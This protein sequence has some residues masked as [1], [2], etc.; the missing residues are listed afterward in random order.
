MSTPPFVALPASV[1]RARWGVRGTE[2]AVLHAG[3][4]D[5]TAWVVM[6]PGFTGSKEDF[7]AVLPLLADAG[8]GVVTFDQIGQ[9]ESDGSDRA[10]DY[11]MDRLAADVGEIVA[12]AAAQFGRIDPPHLLGHSFGGLVAS[13]AVANGSVRPASFVAFC[14]GPGALPP[15]RW[16]TLPDLVAALE[17]SQLADIWRIMREMEVAEDVVPPPPDVAAF[18]EER[19]HAN[20]PVQMQ[21]FARLLM[22]QPDVVDRL[23]PVVAAGLPAVVMW[24]ENDDVWPIPMQARMAADLGATAIELPGVGHSPNAEAPAL[25]VEALLLAWGG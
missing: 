22:S 11:E 1:S 24:G 21:Q 5:A 25:M 12:F 10:A 14:T 2:R 6:V 16:G 23:R 13:E 4:A 9:H 8:V 18:L 17:H 15:E 7:I 3:M 20:H 19:W